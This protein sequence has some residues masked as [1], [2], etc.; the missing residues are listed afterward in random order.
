MNKLLNNFKQATIVKKL[1]Y[2]NIMVFLLT[3]L[4]HTLG[5]LFNLE[6]NVI[7]DWFSMPS[8]TEEFIWRPWSILSYGFLHASF[9]HIFS[10]LLILYYIG[11]LFVEYFSQKQ[12]LN[13]YLYGTA[14]GGLLYLFSY[15]FFPALKN[16]NATLVGASAAVMAIFVG[17]A[18]YMPNYQLK[19][20]FIG[21]VKLWVLA[22]VFIG[23]DLIQIPGGNAGG[24]M[25]HIGGAL[26]GYVYRYTY[27]GQVK[28]SKFSDYFTN[29]FQKKSVLKTVHKSKTRKSSDT[30]NINQQKIDLI[31][32]KISKSGYESLNQEEKDLLFKQGKK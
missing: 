24:H 4:I 8:N 26:F 27:T 25:S 21:Y 11:N 13:F 19:L 15:N 22:A 7:Y 2:I 9:L 30:K 17:I 18:S 23:L 14:F 29:L 6:S 3:H 12:L 10:N 20:R 1:I 28:K 5:Y 31:L 16:S 32:E